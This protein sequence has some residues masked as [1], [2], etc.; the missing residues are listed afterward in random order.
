MVSVEGDPSLTYQHSLQESVDLLYGPVIPDATYPEHLLTALVFT[1]PNGSAH[2]TERR[3]EMKR[4]RAAI[5]QTD[6]FLGTAQEAIYQLRK[7]S[8]VAPSLGACVVNMSTQ[9]LW[10][11][12]YGPA[13]CVVTMTDGQSLPQYVL[14]IPDDSSQGGLL[15]QRYANS[16]PWVRGRELNLRLVVLAQI[17]RKLQAP[18]AGPR[19]SLDVSC[20][21][22]G[23]VEFPRQ[24]Q[25]GGRSA[26]S[27]AAHALQ[28]APN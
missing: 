12:V 23:P 11:G 19:F 25:S 27:L 9:G 10:L 1:D 16:V 18:C 14:P 15:E 7:K 20:S 8:F 24:R 2:Q 6:D 22:T 3:E 21:D 28:L 13:H 4:I 17:D 26:S 5:K